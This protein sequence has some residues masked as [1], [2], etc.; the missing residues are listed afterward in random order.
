MS[1]NSSASDFDI[2]AF[3]CAWPGQETQLR[4]RARARSL[5]L[6]LFTGRMEFVNETSDFLEWHL[7]PSLGV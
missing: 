4:A 3:V 5:S 2:W 6:S 7:T 1:G